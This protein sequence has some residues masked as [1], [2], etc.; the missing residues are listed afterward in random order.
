MRGGVDGSFQSLVVPRVVNQPKPQHPQSIPHQPNTAENDSKK[1]GGYQGK[2]FDPNFHKKKP[3]SD[4][5]SKER[6]K[7][8]FSKPKPQSSQRSDG[9]RS[10]N[11]GYGRSPMAMAPNK[12]SVNS[13]PKSYQYLKLPTAY[14][15]GAA[16]YQV[17]VQQVFNISYADPTGNHRATSRVIE[18]ILTK[19]RSYYANT[20]GQRVATAK[21]FQHTVISKNDGEYIGFADSDLNNNLMSY[22]K[23]VEL[24]PHYYS[25]ISSNPYRKL[26]YGMIMYRVCFPITVDNISLQTKPAED[27]V[28]IDMRI[29]ALSYAEFYAR[30]FKMDIE[31]KYDVWRELAWYKYCSK[32]ILDPKIS[33]HFAMIYTNFMCKDKGLNYLRLL[34]NAATQKDQL[35]EEYARRLRGNALFMSTFE[36]KDGTITYDIEVPKQ[37]DLVK[38]MYGKLPDEINPV[39]QQFSNYA[40]IILTEAPHKNLYQWASKEIKTVGQGGKITS[41]GAHSEEEWT[42]VLFQIAQALYTLQVH[43]I[44]IRDMTVEDNINIRDIDTDKTGKH[45]RYII[46]GITYYVPNLGKCVMI[47]TNYKDIPVDTTLCDDTRDYKIRTTGAIGAPY[48][49][50]DIR[51]GVRQNFARIFNTNI[52]GPEFT[53]NGVRPPPDDILKLLTRIMNDMDDD[54]SNIIV[55][56]FSQYTH[57]RIGGYLKKGTE[58]DNVR[59]S[60]TPFKRGELALLKVDAVNYRIVMVLTHPQD[61]IVT[62]LTKDNPSDKDKIMKDVLVELLLRYSQ[63]ATIEQDITPYDLSDDSVL[64]TYVISG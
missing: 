27:H 51:N 63:A 38:E 43:G 28:G 21:D 53:E 54:I 52:F 20:I 32:K 24:Y 11:M 44:F 36:K 64:E 25:T 35:T 57:N 9:I 31:N 13:D 40:L 37:S 41:N 7:P 47:D 34:K 19:K 29:Y 59:E 42:N 33:P 39:L 22:I 18:A 49:A 23:I 26:P 2:N 4:F 6:S 17:P 62:V 30:E 60:S 58:T 1:P 50:R 45:W 48:D 46:N 10:Q 55:R 12:P 8:D 15:V 16:T 61:G 14:D 3:N 5:H 56:H